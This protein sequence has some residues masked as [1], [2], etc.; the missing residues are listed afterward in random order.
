MAD[1]QSWEES[2]IKKISKKEK[3]TYLG[4]NHP[5]GLSIFQQPNYQVYEFTPNQKL[6]GDR[7]YFV[8]GPEWSVMQQLSL[9]KVEHD[10]L[11]ARLGY[12]VTFEEFWEIWEKG[13]VRF[14][15]RT[16]TPGLLTNYPSSDRTNPD[17]SVTPG[18]RKDVET[19]PG[20]QEWKN[21]NERANPKIRI[22]EYWPDRSQKDVSYVLMGCDRDII[23]AIL[24][25]EW[26]G[27]GRTGEVGK[28]KPLGF[29]CK[30]QPQIILYFVEDDEDVERGWDA[31]D[32]EIS[33]RIMDKST[34]PDSPLPKLEKNDLKAIATKIHEIFEIGRAHV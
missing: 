28:S 1:T 16:G 34:Y 33:F 24:A 21:P 30:G 29:R 10:M 22:I 11:G 23:Q 27:N 15:N 4:S 2:V 3:V 8:A 32:G 17:E 19:R 14:I 26:E 31:I 13:G 12:L 18:W 25:M 6:D 5:Q 20:F 9:L 7:R